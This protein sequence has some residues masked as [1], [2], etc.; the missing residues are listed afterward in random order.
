MDVL[1]EYLKGVPEDLRSLVSELDAL[2][3]TTDPRLVASLKWGNL[4]Y[5]RE[6][7]V[8]AIVAH[9]NHVNLQL[10]PG[11]GIAD[12]KGLLEGSGKR[13]RHVKL[14]PGVDLDRQALIAMVRAT[15]TL[16]ES[17]GTRRRPA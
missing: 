15:A 16:C 4:T 3:R 11:A 6:Q 8:C 2:V 1:T 5:H 13:M 7:N 12:P 14:V 10:W 9:R 17:R